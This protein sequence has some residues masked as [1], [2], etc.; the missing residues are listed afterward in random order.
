MKSFGALKAE[1]ALSSGLSLGKLPLPRI[2]YSCLPFLAPSFSSQICSAVIWKISWAR[3][4]VASAACSFHSGILSPT[5]AIACFIV[6]S[7]LRPCRTCLSSGR[8]L[9][10]GFRAYQMEDAHKLLMNDDHHCKEIEWLPGQLSF[11][12]EWLNISVCLSKECTGHWRNWPVWKFR[13]R[14]VPGA[15][16]VKLSA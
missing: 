1:P 9:H 15:T 8:M 16:G 11:T 10:V 2:P 13:A 3:D 14:W 7:P 12:M 5:A 6:V 4:D